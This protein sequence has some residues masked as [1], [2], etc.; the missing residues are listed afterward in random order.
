MLAG[1]FD[2]TLPL[3]DIADRYCTMLVFIVAAAR[4]VRGSVPKLCA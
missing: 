3:S 4:I 1:F 2:L